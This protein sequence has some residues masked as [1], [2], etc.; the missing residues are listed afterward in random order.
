MENTSVC[1]RNNVWGKST[2]FYIPAIL[3]FRVIQIHAML[4]EVSLDIVVRPYL[5]LHI[6]FC[7]D[8]LFGGSRCD[9]SVKGTSGG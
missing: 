2:W 1:Q 9:C 8:H 4:G 3:R 7:D 5:V 6:S